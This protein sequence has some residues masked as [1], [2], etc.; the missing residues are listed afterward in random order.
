MDTRTQQAQGDALARDET[1]GLI[2]ASKVEGTYVYNGQGEHLGHIYDTMIDKKTGK[3]A[4]AVMSFGGFLGIGERYHPLP[5]S[6]LEYDVRKGG[7][8]VDIDKDVLEGA[9]SYDAGSAPDW[10]DPEYGR[11]V[12]EHYGRP[13]AIYRV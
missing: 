5:W 13:P 1:A 3:T 7:Y 11:R 8:V 12:D 4:Y 6:M 9:P 2:A 10:N